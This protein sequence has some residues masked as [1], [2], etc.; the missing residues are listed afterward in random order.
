MDKERL[1]TPET[2]QEYHLP[3]WE[4]LSALTAAVMC[5]DCTAPKSDSQDIHLS[6]WIRFQ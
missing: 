4:W 1:L 6:A 2:G 5:S 3:N